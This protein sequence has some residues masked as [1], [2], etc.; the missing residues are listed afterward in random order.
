MFHTYRFTL[1]NGTY[2]AYLD[3]GA[4][5]ILS[6]TAITASSPN[7][8]KFGAKNNTGL[9]DVYF[10]YLYYTVAGAYAP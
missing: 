9:Q 4:T 1:K 8:I 5:P 2:N 7:A 6:G 3:G 10:D